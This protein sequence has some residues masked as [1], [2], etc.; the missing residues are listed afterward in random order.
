M[1]LAGEDAFSEGPCIIYAIIV[2]LN[3]DA[4]TLTE[5]T[6]MPRRMFEID[7]FAMILESLWRKLAV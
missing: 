7:H 5:V 3:A 1:W 6:K 2:P 4:R